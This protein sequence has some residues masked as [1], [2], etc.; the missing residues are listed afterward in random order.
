MF[1]YILDLYLLLYACSYYAPVTSEDKG[2]PKYVQYGNKNFLW[3]G[4]GGGNRPLG[5]DFRWSHSE[6]LTKRP[7]LLVK[8]FQ[9]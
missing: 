9:T 8:Q 1:H 6:V 7:V 3:G 5:L 4:G 2:L